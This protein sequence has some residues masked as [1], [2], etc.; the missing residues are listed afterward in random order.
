VQEYGIRVNTATHRVLERNNIADVGTNKYR[1]IEIGLM[2]QEFAP[3]APTAGTWNI[4]D[5]ILEDTPTATNPPGWVCVSDGTFSAATDATGD[6][7]GST[8]VI[9]GIAD[10]SDFYPGDYI[11]TSAGF[12]NSVDDGNVPVMIISIDSATQITINEDSDTAEANITV[13]TIDPVF[14]DMADLAA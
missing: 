11:T 14:K 1:V 3:N 8:G 4:G 13:L 9:T 12:A 5:V 7:D 10:T 6:T 2:K